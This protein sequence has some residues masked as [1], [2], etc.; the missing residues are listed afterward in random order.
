MEIVNIKNKAYRLVVDYKDD[1]QLRK[2]FNSLT[3]E[4]YGFDFEDWYHNG[5]WEDR[6]IPYSL[7]DGPNVVSNVS[8]NVIDFMVADVKRT[9]LQ[10][11]TVMTQEGY[12]NQG[13][14][15][16]LMNKVLEDWRDKVDL[17]YLFANDTVLDFYPKFGFTQVNEYQYSMKIGPEHKYLPD[18]MK[19]NMSQKENQ[20]LLWEMVNQSHHFADITMINNA[21]LIMF[22][23]T[24]FMSQDVYYLKKYDAIVVADFN[25]DV[26]F[27]NDIFCAKEI[28]LDEIISLLINKEVKKVVLGFT[29]KDKVQ[30]DEE[31]LKQ[32][33]TTLFILDDKWGVMENKKQRFPVLSRA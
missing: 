2:S 8:V 4:T 29:P 11:G 21:A 1:N 30:F 23:C 13:L 14:N 7:V 16:I 20:D 25:D 28:S 19:L 15:R 3:Q 12:R 32:E 24:S 9:Y 17:I 26:L 27:L 6:Y 31:L 5:Y 10:I 18:F 33:G 22:Y